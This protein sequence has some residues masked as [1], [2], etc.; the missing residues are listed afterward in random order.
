[1]CVMKKALN[2]VAHVR[3]IFPKG[4]GN[5]GEDTKG[6]RTK[7]LRLGPV[8]QGGVTLRPALT[9]PAGRL[10]FT[11]PREQREIIYKVMERIQGKSDEK[12]P[13]ADLTLNLSIKRS[14]R[15][16]RGN[17]YEMAAVAYDFLCKTEPDLD[18][19]LVQVHYHATLCIGPTRDDDKPFDLRSLGK[20]I[21][22][23]PWIAEWVEVER[24][25]DKEMGRS[26]DWAE[27]GDSHGVYQKQRAC[28]LFAGA[29]EELKHCTVV[30][31]RK[32]DRK[33]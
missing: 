30:H 2:A 22:C 14:T 29:R 16:G 4:A 11:T 26:T 31:R 19:S 21:F 27:P 32:P 7:E 18:I 33:S 3:K 17:C 24:A 25:H 20:V 9:I 13:N 15:N 28:Q 1:M 12:G 23:D 6:M 10:A 5:I 8:V